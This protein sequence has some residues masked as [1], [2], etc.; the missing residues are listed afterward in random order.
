MYPQAYFPVDATFWE[1]LSEHQQV[2]VMRLQA[3]AQEKVG[4][5]RGTQKYFME[6]FDPRSVDKRTSGERL[7]EIETPRLLIAGAM[8]GAAATV[9]L[10]LLAGTVHGSTPAIAALIL[11]TAGIATTVLGRN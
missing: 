10:G 2:E 11:A 9:T 6:D 8:L 4:Y 1:G 5:E 3:V 7:V